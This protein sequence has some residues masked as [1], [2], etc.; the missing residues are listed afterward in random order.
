MN[1]ANYTAWHF[2]R[3]CLDALRCDL[4]SELDGFVFELAPENPKNYQM[5][6][7]RHACTERICAS[8]L[9]GGGV[10]GDAAVTASRSTS[11]VE[12]ARRL[13]AGDEQQRRAAAALDATA[14]RE[15]DFCHRQLLLDGKNLHAWSH[16]QWLVEYFGLWRA[17]LAFVDERITE[18][19]RNNS[20]WNHRFFVVTQQPHT[21]DNTSSTTTTAA[22]AQVTRDS[23]IQFAQQYCGRAPNNSSP[24]AYLRGLLLSPK[25][26][27]LPSQ[28]SQQTLVDLAYRFCVDM[29]Q[30]APACAHA[31]SLALDLVQWQ[32]ERRQ[33]PTTMTSTTTSTTSANRS[34]STATTTIDA[35]PDDLSQQSVPSLKQ[36]AASLCDQLETQ[37]DA[38]HAN[39][40]RYRKAQLPN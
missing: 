15:L 27:P 19:L 36:L 20:A 39:Y 18:D 37:R 38:L 11:I 13:A 3:L 2:R 25:A 14:Q 29:Q 6:H 9:I 10:G 34:S 23:E 8:L 12:H 22:A 26:A 1:P 31:L 17:E 32:I 16:R 35:K 40:W 7:H 4:V 5:W 24:W 28:N 33:S 30:R 21:N